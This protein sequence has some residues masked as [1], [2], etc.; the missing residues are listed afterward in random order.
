MFRL[1]ATRGGERFTHTHEMAAATRGQFKRVP[2]LIR[3]ILDSQV[4]SYEKCLTIRN[5]LDTSAFEKSSVESGLLDHRAL[6][7]WNLSVT[8]LLVC[9]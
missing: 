4:L 9:A 7:N 3:H 8:I 1:A 5:V 6:D 2:E